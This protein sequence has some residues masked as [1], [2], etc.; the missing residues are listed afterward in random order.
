MEP[1][2]EL[3]VRFG[4]SLPPQLPCR[5]VCSRLLQKTVMVVFARSLCAARRARP[6]PRQSSARAFLGS[7]HISCA[8][9]FALKAKLRPRMPRL[10]SPRCRCSCLQA[11]A[12]RA[13]RDSRLRS[14]GSTRAPR[15]G[16]RFALILASSPLAL[17]SGCWTGNQGSAGGRQ[18]GMIWISKI[19]SKRMQF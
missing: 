19:L 17:P 3:R 7:C 5:Q 13:L 16:A 2:P 14:H 9:C 12:G 8:R 11:A 10:S 1:S 4:R 15:E 18:M 6:A